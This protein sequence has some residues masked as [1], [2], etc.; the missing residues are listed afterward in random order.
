MKNTKSK[1]VVLQIL[2]DAKSAYS[3]TEILSL[4]NGE[5][6]KV[7]V[8]RIL[9]RLESEGIIHKIVDFDGVIKYAKCEEQCVA[10]HV[11]HDH[12]H[13]HFSCERCGEL[14]CLPGKIPPVPVEAG[15]QVSEIVV[16]IK[17]I[18]PKCS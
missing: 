18:C 16:N 3:A 12:D 9:E 17:G 5:C 10:H 4:S 8:Y 2:T 1:N 7:T 15:Y 11:H 14:V 6:N 13:L